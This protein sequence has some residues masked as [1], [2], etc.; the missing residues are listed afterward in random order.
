[1]QKLLRSDHRITGI[2]FDS[3]HI[4]SEAI[5]L[6][7]RFKVRVPDNISIGAFGNAV[8]G[9][10]AISIT[11]I[12]QHPVMLGHTAVD[13]LIDQIEGRLKGPANIVSDVELV[14]GET[15]SR[16]LE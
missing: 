10:Q 9:D 8:T 4:A 6:L 3:I 12:D 7:R 13:A 16:L 15:V 1:L 5:N 2:G 11:T 14:K